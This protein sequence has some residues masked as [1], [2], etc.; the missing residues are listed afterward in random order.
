[1]RTLI[2]GVAA[3][4]MLLTASPASAAANQPPVA[5]DDS[6]TYRNNGGTDFVV[7]ALANDSDPDG[8]LLTYSAV[9]PAGK[10]NA[11]LADGKLYYKPYLGNEGT[12][13]FTYTVSDGQGHTASGTVTATLWVDPGAPG[14]ATISIPAPGSATLSWS[15]ADRAVE[16]RIYLNGALV[17]TTTDL[18]W[19]ATGLLDTGY[20]YWNVYAFNGGG[21]RGGAS[22]S[23]S[24]YPKLPT[25]EAVH[26]GGT[27][28]PTTLK[29]T[30]DDGYMLGP[31]NV[32]RDGVLIG[33]SHW[34][35]F[36]D[37]GL[38]TGQEYSYRVELV[39]GTT[40]Q[41][42]YPP[43]SL[44]ATVRG[45]PG[46]LTGIGQLFRNLGGSSGPLGPIITPERGL[47]GG[48]QQD[49]QNG[50]ILERTGGPALTVT[51]P[52]AGAYFGLPM[53]GALGDLGFPVAEQESGLR[54]GGFG[55]LFEG[56][57]IWGSSYTPTRVVRQVIEDGW[58]EA[59]WEEGP[60]GYPVGNQETLPRGV[61]QQFEDGGVY[62][63]AATGSHGVSAEN[64]DTYAAWG[65]PGG[66]LGFPT[67][68]DVCGLRQDGCWQGFQGGSIHWSPAT[69]AHVT[70]GAMRDAW[71]RTGWENGRLGYPTT[72]A[73]C[74]LRGGGC[75]Q[76]FQG[77]TIHWSPATGAHA[78]SGLIRDAWGRNGWENGRLGYPVSGE[79]AS[80]GVIRQNFQG[81]YITVDQRTG[82][83]TVR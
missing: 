23:L 40:A 31:W 83:V 66:R 32:Y 29:L 11:Y 50:Y 7:D 59:G 47:P 2:T 26:V 63:S 34:A 38:V 3:A 68:G 69:G 37:T 22:Y 25:P 8:D 39:G 35:G 1:M 67:T 10:G 30:W 75:W 15:A 9:T 14:N 19:T 13:S 6:V 17:H 70:D 55:Q 62:W 76:G 16:Y 5:V 54:D 33:S 79:T 27:D 57:S 78:T 28:D 65:G 42:V 36:V 74:G 44:S 46:V 4:L 58:A 45:T 48:R 49:H 60:L 53:Y 73:V 61:S 64:H 43:S 51:D 80:G 71:A 21:W 56:G 20:Y 72:D 77:G 82:R 41:S 12:D 81:G 18:S 52:V 24:R